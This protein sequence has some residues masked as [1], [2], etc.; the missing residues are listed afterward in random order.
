MGQ[1]YRPT[2]LNKSADVTANDWN[3]ILWQLDSWSFGQGAKLM[4][5]SYIHNPLVRAV[6]YLLAQDKEG[7]PFVWA[8]DYAEHYNGLTTNLYDFG[9]WENDEDSITTK[10]VRLLPHTMQHNEWLKDVIDYR[11]NPEFEKDYKFVI[12]HSKKLYVVIPPYEK[13]AWNVHPLPLLTA[14]SNGLGGGDYFSET[15]ADLV[16]SWKYDKISVGDEIPSED[17][18]ELK[19]VF[20]E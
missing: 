15:N 4:E 12:N 1:Y 19:A 16:G 6:E 20:K 3:P 9:R 17:Y 10:T 8:G 13:D 14:E 11:L 7:V 2:A 5:H 18:K